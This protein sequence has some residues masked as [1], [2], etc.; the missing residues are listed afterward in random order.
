MACIAA[1]W[2]AMPAAKNGNVTQDTIST[3]VTKPEIN[4]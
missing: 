1:F 4:E 3:E 2:R